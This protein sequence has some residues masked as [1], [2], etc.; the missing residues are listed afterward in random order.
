M[1]MVI[2]MISETH[3]KVHKNWD[4]FFFEWTYMKTLSRHQA[5]N[6]SDGLGY[7]VELS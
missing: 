7:H 5:R 4:D 6:I 3:N 2:K 1:V